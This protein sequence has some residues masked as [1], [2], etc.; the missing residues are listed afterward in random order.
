[1]RQFKDIA[2]YFDYSFAF[3]KALKSYKE[4]A[5]KMILDT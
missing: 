3:K 5:K 4:E 1:M 2:I